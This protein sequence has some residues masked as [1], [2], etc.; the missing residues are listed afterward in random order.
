MFTSQTLSYEP[1]DESKVNRERLMKRHEGELT[2]FAQKQ[3]EY[4]AYLDELNQFQ[5]KYY[6]SRAN[7]LDNLYNIPAAILVSNNGS[8]KIFLNLMRDLVNFKCSMTDDPLLHGILINAIQLTSELAH[9]Q[10]IWADPELAQAS[11]GSFSEAMQAATAFIIKPS[12]PKNHQSLRSATTRMK[13][14]YNNLNNSIHIYAASAFLA[15]L[16]AFIAITLPP[17]GIAVGL[18]LATVAGGVSGA[19]FFKSRIAIPDETHRTI[20]K[21]ADYLTNTLIGNYSPPL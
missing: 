18:A 17:V 6:P 3:Q 16:G 14:R 9:S 19:T 10:K 11:M 7:L 1:I 15:L 13:C 8:A 4:I 21:T 12:N 5:K 20:C 2:A